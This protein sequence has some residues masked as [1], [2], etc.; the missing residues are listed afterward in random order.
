MVAFRLLAASAALPILIAVTPV[1]LA[2]SEDDAQ[3]AK[4]T[5]AWREKREKDLRAPDGWLAVAGLFFL[6]PGSNSFG[7]RPQ[8]DIVLPPGSAPDEVGALSLEGGRVWL[9]V[10]PGVS[11]RVNEGAVSGR[12][13]LRLG[14]ADGK[15]P[16]DRVWVGRVS[17]HLHKS[18][19]RLGVRLRDPES[20]IRTKFTGLRWFPIGRAF[21]VTGKFIRYDAPKTIPILNILGDVEPSTSSGEVE[22]TVNGQHVRLVAV[23]SGTRLWFI[24]RDATAAQNLTYRIRFLY[25]DAPVGTSDDVVL[26]FNRAYNPPCAY[27]PHT[28]CPLPPARNRLSVAIPAGEKRYT[29]HVTSQ[30]R[31]DAQPNLGLRLTLSSDL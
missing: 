5:Q 30:S 14:D 4:E 17:L 26:D 10:K 25:A 21:R 12:T 28:T 7:A 9:D 24:F 20:S 31:P 19:E 11:V 2:S 15:R 8:S 27:N 1:A 13:E 29:S 16:A 6:H 23:D 22:A 18:G 3:I